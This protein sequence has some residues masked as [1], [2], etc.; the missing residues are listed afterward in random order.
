MNKRTIIKL[1][2]GQLALVVCLGVGASAQT[3]GGDGGTISANKPKTTPAA[4]ATAK[5]IPMPA[6]TEFRK[7]SIGITADELKKAWGK[8]EVADKT[9]FIYEFSDKEMAQVSITGDEKVDAIAVT[10]RDGTGAPKAEDIFGPNERIERKENGSVFHMVR[11]PEAGYWV[12]YLSQGEGKMVI[13]T[14]KK[15]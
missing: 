14:Y 5:T 2:L 11:Y 6:M 9:G 3:A 1:A 7:A 12:S 4:A 13:L 10:F 8:P 15:I